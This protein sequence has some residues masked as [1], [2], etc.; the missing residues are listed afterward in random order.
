MKL[1]NCLNGPFLIY[2]GTFLRTKTRK[3]CLMMMFSSLIFFKPSMYPLSSP[4]SLCWSL[5][6]PFFDIFQTSSPS[7]MHDSPYCLILLVSSKV[8]LRLSSW[9]LQD[10]CHGHLRGFFKEIFEA[11]IFLKDLF[12]LIQS[13]GFIELPP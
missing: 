6:Q 10:I 5:I 9:L 2:F 3:P 12:K 1:I 4:S 13:Q 7:N 11:L 8:I